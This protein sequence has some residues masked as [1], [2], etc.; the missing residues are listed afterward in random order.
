MCSVLSGRVEDMRALLE[1][2]VKISVLWSGSM[3]GFENC[4]PAVVDSAMVI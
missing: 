1:H 2:L 4:M 3:S